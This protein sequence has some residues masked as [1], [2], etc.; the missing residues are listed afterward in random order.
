MEELKKIAESKKP[1]EETQKQEKKQNIATDDRHLLRIAI[2]RAIDSAMPH[3]QTAR[4]AMKLKEKNLEHTDI[5]LYLEA[6]AHMKSKRKELAYMTAN[7]IN[8]IFL[9]DGLN[10]KLD[11]FFA[12]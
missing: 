8:N 5:L 10:Q 6:E 9:K 4:I 2:G 1:Q 3:F 11:R 7:T 12:Q